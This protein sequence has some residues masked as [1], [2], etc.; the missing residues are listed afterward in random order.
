VRCSADVHGGNAV[1]I[2]YFLVEL[3]T[4]SMWAKL[5][6]SDTCYLLKLIGVVRVW[7]K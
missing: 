4:N 2:C 6:H 1:Y 5:Y 3:V 7:I